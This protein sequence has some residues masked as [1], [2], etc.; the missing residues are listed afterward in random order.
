MSSAAVPAP[1]APAGF[2]TADTCPTC[3]GWGVGFETACDEAGEALVIVEANGDED[4]IA[5]L[6]PCD[7]CDGIG[8]AHAVPETPAAVRL[9]KRTADHEEF[10]REFGV[11]ASCSA[12]AAWCRHL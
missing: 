4:E 8:F 6:A 7:E 3:S 1:T 12:A 5:T 9:A 2:T 11:G 10:V